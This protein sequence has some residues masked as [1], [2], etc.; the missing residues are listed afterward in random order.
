MT[1]EKT[2]A[3]L[4]QLILDIS[5]RKRDVSFAPGIFSEDFVLGP[6]KITVIGAPPATGKTALAQQI[7]FDE[8]DAWLARV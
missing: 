1:F 8:R 5:E 7:V 3:A 4:G 2:G 6:G